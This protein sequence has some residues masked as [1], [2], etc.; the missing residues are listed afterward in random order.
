ML[1]R[2]QLNSLHTASKAL[3][4]VLIIKALNCWVSRPSTVL[5][6]MSHWLHVNSYKN[7]L[8]FPQQVVWMHPTAIS[9]IFGSK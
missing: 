4:P 8:E 5:R 1:E 9:L 6:M 2:E 3:S 7:G